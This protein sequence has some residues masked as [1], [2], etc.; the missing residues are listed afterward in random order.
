MIIGGVREIENA[1]LARRLRRCYPRIEVHASRDDW[2]RL[3]VDDFVTF[4]AS[5]EKLVAPGV[6]VDLA[7]DRSV[8]TGAQ[9]HSRFK[10]QETEYGADVP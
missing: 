7:V 2:L 4:H 6:L 5:F 9:P 8:L 3:G 10:V 1:A